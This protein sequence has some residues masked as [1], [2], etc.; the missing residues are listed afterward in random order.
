MADKQDCGCRVKINNIP[1]TPT[2]LTD[3]PAISIQ[4]CP[5]HAAA[6]ELL[7]ALK[8]FHTVECICEGSMDCMFTKL[9]SRAEGKDSK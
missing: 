9:I 2:V 1:G 5:L 7:E 3:W 4:F 6:P 8:E